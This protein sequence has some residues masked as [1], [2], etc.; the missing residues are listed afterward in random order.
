MTDGFACFGNAY[1]VIIENFICDM[2]ARAFI[3]CIKG[4]GWYCACE[5]CTII[6]ECSQ[7]YRKVVYCGRGDKRTEETFASQEQQQHHNGTSPLLQL[8][9]DLVS[10]VPLDYMHLVCSG[11]MKRLLAEYWLSTKPCA[12]NLSIHTKTA[13]SE[14]L[15]SY[16]PH[17]PSEIARKP[18][19]LG[20]VTSGR[21][22]SS[23]N[24]C[25]T[26]DLPCCEKTWTV[27]HTPFSSFII[28]DCHS[29]QPI[30]LSDNA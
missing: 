16:T 1:K 20:D 8:D 14:L 11:V 3:K 15:I 30:I 12:T 4:H 18:R 17:V 6:G 10:G 7:E 29:C 9:I 28:C 25:C 19:G 24:V 26:Q 13:I 2:P 22:Q 5:K 27:P 23:D 21:P